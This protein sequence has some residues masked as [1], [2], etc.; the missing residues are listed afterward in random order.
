MVGKGPGAP[1]FTVGVSVCCIEQPRAE[2][3]KTSPLGRSAGGGFESRKALETQ[4]APPAH[5]S[6]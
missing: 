2:A 5:N 6:G 4:S 3:E 1:F